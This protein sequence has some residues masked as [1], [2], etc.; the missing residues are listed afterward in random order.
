MGYA[1]RML[2]MLVLLVTTSAMPMAAWGQTAS[3]TLLGDARDT[4]GAALPGV[5]VTAT[6]QANG[7]IRETV[8][9]SLGTYRFSALTPGLYTVSANLPGFKQAV[10]TDVRVNIASQVAVPLALEV[11]GVEEKVTVEIGR[12]HV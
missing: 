12:A 2:R 3:G 6:N 1:S 4:T 10:R 5:T 11:S 9:D 8:T 7:A